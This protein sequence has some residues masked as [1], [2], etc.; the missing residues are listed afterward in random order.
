MIIV[1]T[2]EISLEYCN[3][4]IAI[5]VRSEIAIEF[6]RVQDNG[7]FNER[8]IRL[9]LYEKDFFLSKFCIDTL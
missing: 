3:K 6:L 7:A 4:I 1:S 9:G 2:D 8:G 5:R